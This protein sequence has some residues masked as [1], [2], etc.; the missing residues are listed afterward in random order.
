MSHP[1]V[2]MGDGVEEILEY[3]ESVKDLRAVY[4]PNIYLVDIDS[5]KKILAEGYILETSHRYQLK[6]S[7]NTSTGEQITQIVHHY[8]LVSRR[9]SSF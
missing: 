3:G 4:G 7:S 5:G 1:V 8:P 9:K 6:R 2:D